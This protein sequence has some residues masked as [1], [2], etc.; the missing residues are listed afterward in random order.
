LGALF[1]SVFK[2][3]MGMPGV[4]AVAQQQVAIT[5]PSGTFDDKM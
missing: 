5:T 2:T 4:T 1:F 3:S